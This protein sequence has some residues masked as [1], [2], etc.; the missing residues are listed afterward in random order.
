[1][2]KPRRTLSSP[3]RVSGRHVAPVAGDVAGQQAVADVGRRARFQAAGVATIRP[4]GNR[5]LIAVLP[6]PKRPAQLCREHGLDES[7]LL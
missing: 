6:S 2:R 3:A 1:M 7:V 4:S 5:A